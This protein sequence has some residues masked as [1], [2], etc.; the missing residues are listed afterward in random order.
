MT[1][2]RI[3]TPISSRMRGAGFGALVGAIL[4][5]DQFLFG[6]LNAGLAYRVSVLSYLTG[7]GRQWSSMFCAAVIAGGIVGLLVVR[8]TRYKN[9]IRGAC[10][11]LLLVVA[12]MIQAWSQYGM[13]WKNFKAQQ[14]T[15][16]TI[17]F[18]V[19]YMQIGFLIGLIADLIESRP[20]LADH[21]GTSSRHQMVAE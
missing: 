8:P 18:T 4:F 11:G 6:L 19:V 3:R 16:E 13:S 10:T 15:S 5:L 1:I 21:D 9:A 2:T 12:E 20:A 14:I 7:A 17:I